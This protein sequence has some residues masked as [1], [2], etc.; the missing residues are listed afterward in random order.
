MSVR[1]VK[2]LAYSTDFDWVAET[3]TWIVI[4]I[5]SM[6]KEGFGIPDPDL[7][8]TTLINETDELDGVKY[9][10][11]FLLKQDETVKPAAGVVTWYRIIPLSGSNGIYV[12]GVDGCAV[13]SFLSGVR[14]LGDGQ[15]FEKFSNTFAGAD[16][17]SVIK[18]L[19]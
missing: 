5:I 16:S 13:K 19:P 1:G 14:A 10:F 6:L 7:F 2:E 12:G 11:E 9:T 18:N 15:W 8:E 4:P 17:A 3:G